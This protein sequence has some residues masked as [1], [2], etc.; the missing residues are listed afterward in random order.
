VE[1]SRGD[2]NKRR[3]K[4]GERVEMVRDVGKKKKKK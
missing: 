3:K 1:N 4:S 2:E